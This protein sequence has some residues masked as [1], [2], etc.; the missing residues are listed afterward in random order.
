MKDGLEFN[1]SAGYS[2]TTYNRSGRKS[3]HMK[4]NEA[5]MDQDMDYDE[6]QKNIAEY[7]NSLEEYL[8]NDNEQSEMQHFQQIKSLL[9][10]MV[11]LS[12]MAINK[13]SSLKEEADEL[14]VTNADLEQKS[15]LA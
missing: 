6:I 3:I 13:S 5:M 14:R 11:W 8:Q 7:K 1:R 2:Q 10:Q 12:N 4:N 15:A 9:G